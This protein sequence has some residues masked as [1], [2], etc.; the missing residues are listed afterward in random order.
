MFARLHRHA[1][2]AGNA[3]LRYLPDG[4][5]GYVSAP[6]EEGQVVMLAAALH[7][8]TP[9]RGRHR[10]PGAVQ[11]RDSRKGHPKSKKQTVLKLHHQ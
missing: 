5:N 6:P 9:P 7:K 4:V 8:G 11:R 2:A 1:D 3:L 10:N